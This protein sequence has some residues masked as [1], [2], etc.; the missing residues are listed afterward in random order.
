[1]HDSRP[2]SIEVYKKYCCKA[3]LIVCLSYDKNIDCV[4]NSFLRHWWLKVTVH[5]CD[6]PKIFEIVCGNHCLKNHIEK[7]AK[8][9]PVETSADWLK[10]KSKKVLNASNILQQ[11]KSTNCHC[12][13]ASRLRIGQLKPTRL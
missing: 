11:L 3:H 12:F 4:A 7:K 6:I 8:F 10:S 5:K 9:M 13:L 2:N 1:M